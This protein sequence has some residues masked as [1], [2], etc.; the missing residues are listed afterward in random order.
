MV[1]HD[2]NDLFP[3]HNR[4]KIFPSTKMTGWTGQT[5]KSLFTKKRENRGYSKKAP[6]RDFLSRAFCGLE[7]D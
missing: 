7:H 3:Q 1:L 2:N 4:Q 6:L 5:E